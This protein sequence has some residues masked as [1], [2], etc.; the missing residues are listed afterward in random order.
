MLIELN[1][2]EEM[3]LEEMID[4]IYL[5]MMRSSLVFGY[6]SD[7]KYPLDGQLYWNS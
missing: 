1:I 3:S 6:R 7:D 2:H 5:K 4:L